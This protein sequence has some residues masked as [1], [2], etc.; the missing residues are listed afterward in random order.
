[1]NLTK[2]LL[3]LITV[4][5][6][7]LMTACSNDESDTSLHNSSENGWGYVGS[8]IPPER[9]YIVDNCM[10]AQS[11]RE[12]SPINI[13]TA[14]AIEKILPT[15]EYHYNDSKVHSTHNGHTVQID[16]SEA[17]EQSYI[18]VGEKKFYLKQFHF[19]TLSEH[20]I[21]GKSSPIEMHLVHKAED[22]S[23]AVVGVMIDE[24]ERNSFLAEVWDNLPREK[25]ATYD[26]QSK[27]HLKGLLPEN[28][29]VYRFNGSLTT[30]PCTEGVS[31]TIMANHIEMDSMQIDAFKALFS[32]RVFGEGNRRPL[33][34]LYNRE[35][36]FEQ[37]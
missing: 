22:D 14:T 27:L 33:Q 2:Y 29:A 13:I 35:V 17:E 8:A 32:G 23:L 1:M 30:P 11:G 25:G 15:M 10:V 21:D 6:P 31:W 36:V 34:P 7:I 28:R 24:G 37:Q 18:K 5:V 4:T 20:Q 3:L 9:L 26:S 16:V 12:Q 19:H